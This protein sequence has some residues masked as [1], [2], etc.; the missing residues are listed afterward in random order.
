MLLLG[1]LA[2]PGCA[3]G[4]PCRRETGSAGRFPPP[5]VTCQSSKSWYTGEVQSKPQTGT[6]AAPFDGRQ[7]WRDADRRDSGSQAS[8]SYRQPSQRTHFQFDE[9]SQLSNPQ[10]GG[11]SARS[12]KRGVPTAWTTDVRDLELLDPDRQHQPQTVP[13]RQASFPAALTLWKH[14]TC[15]L[16]H[17]SVLQLISRCISRQWPCASA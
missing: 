2:V 17:L 14:C 15:L 9:D 6:L 4:L 12:Q 13:G 10:F 5:T 11:S 7:Q 16:L 3:R 1:R 8:T